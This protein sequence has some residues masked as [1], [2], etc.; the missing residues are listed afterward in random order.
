MIRLMNGMVFDCF[1]VLLMTTY[2]KIPS[3]SCSR[4]E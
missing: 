3:F 2:L 4:V 1:I